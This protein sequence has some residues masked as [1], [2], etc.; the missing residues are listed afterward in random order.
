M[1][2]PNHLQINKSQMRTGTC[3]VSTTKEIGNRYTYD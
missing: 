1:K 2:E 3:D